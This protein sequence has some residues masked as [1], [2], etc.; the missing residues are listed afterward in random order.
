MWRF[1]TGNAPNQTDNA[2]PS[3][4]YSSDLELSNCP[5]PKPLTAVPTSPTQVVLTFDRRIDP[6]TVLSTGEQFTFT[7]GLTATA[8]SLVDRQITLTTSTQAAGADYTVTVAA[9]VKDLL[10]TSVSAPDNTATFKGFSP[11][12]TGPSLVINEIDADN[13]GTDAAEFVEIYNR[14][15]QAA[16]LTNVVLLLVNGDSTTTPRSEYQRFPLTA[17]TDASGNSVTSLP[18]GGYIVGASATYFSSTPPPSTAL[19]LV[20]SAGGSTP[21]QNI[22]QNGADGIGL[23]DN[24]SGTLLDAVFYK[25]KSNSTGKGTVFDISTSVGTKQLDFLEGTMAT[26][27]Q[28]I[29]SDSLQRFPNGSDTN[30]NDHDFVYSPTAT[31]G[32]ANQ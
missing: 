14:G 9:S 25:S 26:G 12:P 20:L 23:L 24:A 13:P 32:A 27:D 1:T 28:G 17:V 29:G 10:G 11:P 16:D 19:R 8:A 31:P 21:D 15:G 5:A 7:N 6:A 22:I 3:A 4:Y 2:Q 30:D 18:S